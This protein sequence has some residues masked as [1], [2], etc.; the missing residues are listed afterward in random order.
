MATKVA[1]LSVQSQD[2]EAGQRSGAGDVYIAPSDQDRPTPY[3]RAYLSPEALKSL[4][5]KAGD[6]VLLA[7]KAPLAIVQLWPRPGVK[8]GGALIRPL[9]PLND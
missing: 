3:R 8:G 4:S 5:V 9:D 7:D 2:W 6:W 1:R